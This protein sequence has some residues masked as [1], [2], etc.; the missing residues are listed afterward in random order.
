MAKLLVV[1]DDLEVADALA[2]W[3]EL[4]GFA[5]EK[6]NTGGDALQLLATYKYDLLILDWEL[7]DVHGIN[8][9]KKFRKEGGNIPILFLTGKSDIKSKI[10]GFETGADDYLCKPFDFQELVVRIQSLLRRPPVLLSNQLSIEGLTLFL[11][12]HKVLVAGIEVSLTPREFRVLEFL[13]RHPNQAFTSKALLDSVWKSESA[14]SIDTVRSC[15]LVLRKKITVGGECVIKT[16]PGY[17]YVIQ[18]EQ[19]GKAKA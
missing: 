3:L 6:A 12:S 19:S 16:E 18:T 11:D 2:T 9:C 17:G 14:F 15:M 5:V 4:Q 8:I 13:M 7:P 10:L 1:E